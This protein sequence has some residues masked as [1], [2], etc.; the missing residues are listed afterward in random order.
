[1]TPARLLLLASL[2]AVTWAQA[3]TSKEVDSV[4]PDAHALYLD[5]H[6]NPELSA[7]E[8]QTAAKLA[9]RLRSAGYDVTQ[10]VGGTGVVAILKNGPGP[11]IMLRTVLDA[12][13]V[14][15]KT[16]LPYASKVHAKDDAGRDVPVMHACGHDLHMA[17][18]LGT[19]E[20]MAR[21][22]DG[23]HGTLMLIGQPAE[24]TISG[25]EGMIRDG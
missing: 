4:Y 1:M 11:T 22:K 24:E 14:E 7:H 23:W 5:L 10:H 8:V 2:T 13:P 17:A 12:L 20:I 21:S 3:P 25:A 16:G 6:E 15:E 19:A 9:A 18:I